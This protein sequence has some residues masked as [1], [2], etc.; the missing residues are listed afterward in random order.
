MNFSTRSYEKELLDRDDIP[1]EDIRQN[2]RELDIINTRLGGHAITLSGFKRLLNGRREVL[3]CEIGCGGGDNL[4]AILR[5]CRKKNITVQLMGIDI[6]PDCVRVASAALSSWGAHLV[7]SDYKLVNF[8]SAKPDIIFS[9]LF[10]HHFT[11]EQLTEMLQWMDKNA[12]LGFFI[13]D[14]HRHFLA[15]YS[16]KWIT[17]LFS[18]SYLVKNDAPLS[19]RRGFVRSEWKALLH[20]AGIARGTLRWRWAFRWLLVVNKN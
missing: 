3:V 15:Y 4:A 7:T 13:N 1:F 20:R 2:M 16:I 14:L 12:R 18:K 5:W 19:V 11:D 17:A 6:N 10:C 9:S 8:G